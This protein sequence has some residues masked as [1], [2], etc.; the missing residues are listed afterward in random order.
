MANKGGGDTGG[1]AGG[2]SGGGGPHGGGSGGGSGGG[3][4]GAPKGGG[5]GGGG[6]GGGGGD[7]KHAGARQWGDLHVHGSAKLHRI[8]EVLA[9]AD[10]A[11]SHAVTAAEM[12][13][14]SKAAA[15][16]RW[17]KIGGNALLIDGG[18][19]ILGT[20]RLGPG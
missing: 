3:E 16:S 1:G 5:T 7:P 12:S 4:G 11:A 15:G 17:V 19:R 6:G 2:G 14:L 9:A 13:G 10:L 20:E 8:G 18:A